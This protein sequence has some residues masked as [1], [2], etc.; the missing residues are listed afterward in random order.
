MSHQGF[1]S[2]SH[3]GFDSMSHQG[4]GSLWRQTGTITAS[5][6][7]SGSDVSA[8][9]RR[10]QQSNDSSAPAAGPTTGTNTI[11]G[12]PASIMPA[13]GLV[14]PQSVSAPISPSGIVSGKQLIVVAYVGADGDLKCGPPDPHGFLVPSSL[15]PQTHN[16]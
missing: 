12:T 14:K 10:L 11:S 16:W 13:G 9:G 3:K 1:D 15:P 5:S 4:L 2:M 6:V 8:A 7:S